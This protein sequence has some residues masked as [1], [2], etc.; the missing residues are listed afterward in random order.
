MCVFLVS[1]LF[2]VM[3]KDIGPAA[4][5]LMPVIYKVSLLCLF[6][7]WWAS[8]TACS[9]DIQR[10]TFVLLLI[11][12]GGCRKHTADVYRGWRSTMQDWIF[13][14]GRAHR[15]LEKIFF[16]LGTIYEWST[17]RP[18]S[19]LLPVCQLFLCYLNSTNFLPFSFRASQTKVLQEIRHPLVD[20]FSSNLL[21]SLWNMLFLCI[22]V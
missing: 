2:R 4:S 11:E 15:S 7:F 14:G 12:H 17:H 19:H 22:D 1:S 18:R 10:Q 9:G 16:G 20:F 8:F 21:R 5:P 13:S 6:Y 3:L